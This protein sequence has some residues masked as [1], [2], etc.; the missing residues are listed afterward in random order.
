MTPIGSD[1]EFL[2]LEGGIH[3]NTLKQFSRGVH[4]TL[5]ERVKVMTDMHV[6]PLEMMNKLKE[7]NDV[8]SI[9]TKKQLYNFK[10]K[11]QKSKG[12]HVET[13]KQYDLWINARLISGSNLAEPPNNSEGILV[14]EK[15]NAVSHDHKGDEVTD[16]GFA[17][18][19]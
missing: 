11:L 16:Y 3:N 12:A 19:I 15:F 18:H 10:K 14:L 13:A 2:L 6:K 8:I 17:G 5:C 7:D 1:G 4:P 9:P